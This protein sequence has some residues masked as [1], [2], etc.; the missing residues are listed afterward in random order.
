MY[1]DNSNSIVPKS[2]KVL[3]DRC[4]KLSKSGTCNKRDVGAL[5]QLSNGG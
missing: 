5:L 4:S 3:L 1:Q 2:V